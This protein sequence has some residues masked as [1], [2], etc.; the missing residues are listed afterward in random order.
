MVDRALKYSV[1]AS[2]ICH[3]LLFLGLA[4]AV[5]L[6][7]FDLQI[8]PPKV[9]E[10]IVFDLTPEI[11]PRNKNLPDEIIETPDDAKTVEQQDDAD[12]LSDKNAVARNA[13][14]ALNVKLGDPYSKGEMQS[15]EV[16]EKKIVQKQ[17][18][19]GADEIV[20]TMQDA[21]NQREYNSDNADYYVSLQQEKFKPNLLKKQSEK[22]LP[23][24]L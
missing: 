20:K 1:Y 12:F 13:E 3:F 9:D 5:R 4:Q 7:L 11:M 21:D 18:E 6:G 24:E 15:H 17:Q 14:T 2:I 22:K 8:K 16:I 19:A 10:P 23:F